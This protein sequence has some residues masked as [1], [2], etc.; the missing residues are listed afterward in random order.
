MLECLIFQDGGSISEI[1]ACLMQKR[2]HLSLR[3]GPFEIG[4]AVKIYYMHA[5]RASHELYLLRGGMLGW[6]EG[7]RLH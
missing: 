6:Y 5:G 7:S 1:T 2:V 3:L 4:G